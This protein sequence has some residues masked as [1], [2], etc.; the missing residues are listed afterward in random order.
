MKDLY[1]KNFNPLKKDANARIKG[2]KK[3]EG[4]EELE[5][6][7]RGVDGRHWRWYLFLDLSIANLLPK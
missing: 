7:Q 6:F 3:G 2:R 4:V 5:A 1:N